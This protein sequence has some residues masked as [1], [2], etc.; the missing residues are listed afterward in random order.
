MLTRLFFKHKQHK[1]NKA[2]RKNR[3][4]RIQEPESRRKEQKELLRSTGY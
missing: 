4:V 2:E 3:G 1:G